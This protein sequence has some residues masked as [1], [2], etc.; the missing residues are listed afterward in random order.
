[1]FSAIHQENPKLTYWELTELTVQFWIVHHP[2]VTV[3][4]LMKISFCHLSLAV[5]WPNFASLSWFC[6]PSGRVSSDIW[7]SGAQRKQ[8][9]VVLMKNPKISAHTVILGYVRQTDLLSGL[10][11][12]CEN[13]HYFSTS[14]NLVT[15][16]WW[17]IQNC[18]VF[19]ISTQISAH[20]SED[21]TFSILIWTYL[22]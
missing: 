6:G 15:C 18:T 10:P 4:C 8:K 13:A 9:Y 20:S 22:D 17:T 1:M 14:G 5:T 3:T 21:L 19:P 12:M 7:G 16:D 11:V 2:P